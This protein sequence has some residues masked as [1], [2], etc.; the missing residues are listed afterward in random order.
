MKSYL[1]ATSIA[2]SLAAATASAQAPDI[3]GRWVGRT[4]GCDDLVITVSNQAPNGVI[5]GTIY[6]T[7]TGLGAP[8]G[9]KLIQGKQMSGK[10]DGTNLSLEGTRGY[11]R[12][13]LE[14]GKLVGHTAGGGLPRTE[15]TLVK[16]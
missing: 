5:E 7:R 8:F 3:K 12:A 13:K 16:Q 14:G 4:S 1:V 2:L 9:E 15:V 6:C 11:T 10:F